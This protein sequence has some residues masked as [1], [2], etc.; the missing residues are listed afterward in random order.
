[1]PHVKMNDGMACKWRSGG[2]ILIQKG[3]RW[4]RSIYRTRRLVSVSVAGQEG[5]SYG[6]R[7]IG[8]N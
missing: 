1:M 3:K 7:I 4:L 6:Y 8:I 5:P 2:F